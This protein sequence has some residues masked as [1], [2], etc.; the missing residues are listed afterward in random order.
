MSFEHYLHKARTSDLFSVD[1]SWGQGRTLFG[2]V[3][4]AIALEK[5][6]QQ[7]DISR[8]LRSLS[9]SFCGATLADQ[10]FHVSSQLL[11]EGK[12]VSQINGH[13]IQND[14]VVTQITACYGIERESEVEVQAQPVTIPELG[15][16][17]RMSYIS[18]LTPEFVQHIDYEYTRGQ[19]PFSNSQYNELAGW[20]RFR[21]A[22]EAMSESHLIALID[23]WP[24]VA[25]QKLKKLAPAATVTWNLEIVQPLSLLEKPLTAGEWLY[26]EAEIQQA[27]HGY[28]HTEAKVYSPDGT[29]IALSRQLVTIYG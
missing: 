10:D 6:R 8:P 15:T 17:Q 11:S 4:A 23:S 1:R 22:N 19:F 5:A 18:G 25:L 20:M 26:Y 28:V 14:K 12:S 16:G 21:D 27:H 3:S 13:I 7:I 29:L 2:G 9:V 24:P